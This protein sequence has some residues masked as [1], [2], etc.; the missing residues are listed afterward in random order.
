[1]E[2]AAAANGIPPV[3]AVLTVFA[4]VFAAIGWLRLILAGFREGTLFGLVALFLPPLALIGLVPRWRQHREI[5][6]LA[7][8]ALVFISI[9]GIF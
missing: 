9:A 1:M 3:A 7:L 4:L 2:T 5:Y 8:G 6:A